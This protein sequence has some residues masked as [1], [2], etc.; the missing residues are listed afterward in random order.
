MAYSIF[1]STMADMTYQDIETAAKNDSIVLFPIS[2]IEEHG[3]HLPL[4][5]DTYV[6]YKQAIAVK[7]NLGKENIKAIIA[8]PFYWGMNFITGSFTGSF[9]L[10][11]STMIQVLVDLLCNLQKWGF[12]KIFTTYCHGDPHHNTA[13]LEAFQKARIDFGIEAYLVLSDAEISRFNADKYIDCIVK[14]KSGDLPPPK[15]PKY[16]D[17]HAGKFETSYLNAEFPETV[18]TDIAKKLEPSKTTPEDFIT[19]RKGGDFT[20]KV[21]PLGYCGDPSDI[22]NADEIKKIFR[23]E[24]KKISDAIIKFINRDKGKIHS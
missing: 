12:K 20:K 7:K 1:E 10:Q 5:T 24:F 18:R 15:P 19:W 9:T 3:P 14:I 13:I 11:K 6:A 16:M 8:P 2:V 21:T 22:I 17:V 23:K 4:A